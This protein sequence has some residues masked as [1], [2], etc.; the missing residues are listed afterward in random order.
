M[1]SPKQ[2]RLSWFENCLVS[3]LVFCRL[4]KIFFFFYQKSDFLPFSQKII[5]FS[6][7]WYHFFFFFRMSGLT[8]TLKHN[9]DF[10]ILFQHFIFLYFISTSLILFFISDIFEEGGQCQWTWT[11][12]HKGPVIKAILHVVENLNL[13]ICYCKCYTGYINKH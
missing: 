4:S 5:I 7:I 3:S 9:V 11:V 12:L 10:S 6:Q 13:P 1:W 8:P 2:A